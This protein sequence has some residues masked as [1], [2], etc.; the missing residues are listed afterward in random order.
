MFFLLCFF[1]AFIIPR[2]HVYNDNINNHDST[3]NYTND[4]QNLKHEGITVV[5]FGGM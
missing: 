1:N 2:F 3:Q 5:R 4:G